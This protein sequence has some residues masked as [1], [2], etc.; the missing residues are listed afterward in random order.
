MNETE[1][2][3]C[4]DPQ[5]MLDFM[6]DGASPR[7]IDLYTT[8]SYRSVLHLVNDERFANKLDER[9]RYFDGLATVAELD[10]AI[11]AADQVPHAICLAA[12]DSIPPQCQVALIRDLFGNPF[13]PVRF[14]PAW[15]TLAVRSRAQTIYDKRQ[16]QDMSLLSIA[17]EEAG[18]A[19]EEILSH[20]CQP[21][22]HWRGC[23]V[24]DLVLAKD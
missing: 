15:A 11:H 17:L 2:L 6:F 23:W 7:K 20:C 22:E 5:M 9:E 24:I 16:F 1:W 3:H 14:E 21:G 8:G 13:H 12:W 19:N 10:A 18:C 4:T